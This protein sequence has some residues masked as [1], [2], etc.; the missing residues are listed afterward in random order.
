M[1]YFVHWCVVRGCVHVTSQCVETEVS[2]KPTTT[3]VSLSVDVMAGGE[4]QPKTPER[5]IGRCGLGS[6][7]VPSQVMHGL[8]SVD[9]LLTG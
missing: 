7:E 4:P 5:V 6:R 2:S 3:D 8:L 9:I 1:L